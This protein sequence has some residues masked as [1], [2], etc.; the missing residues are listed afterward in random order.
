MISSTGTDRAGSGDA[1][2]AAHEEAIGHVVQAMGRAR[3]LLYITGAGM[4]ADSGLPT[5]RGRDGLYRAQ[6]TTP[7]GLPIER[8]LSGPILRTRPEVTWHYLLELE[9]S[10]RGAMPHRGHEVLAEMQDY[11]DDVCILTQNVDGLHQRAGSRNVIDIHGNLHELACMSCGWRASVPHYAGLDIPP[12]CPD[13][14]G[15]VRP[16]VVLFDED[17][18]TDKLQRL[19][20]ELTTGFD[21][22][23][24]IGTSSLFDY[25][26][27]PVRLG[28][29]MG[30]LT[31][32]I[33]PELTRV[34]GM[35]HLKIPAGAAAVLDA[36]WDRYLAWWPWS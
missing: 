14:Q 18:P 12:R 23:F 8:A 29:R 10:T 15:V 30:V 25:I 31:V 7:H 33:N 21:V 34:S 32:E 20:S 2:L 13:C 11:F 9:R 5:Y 35:V 19:W 28:R 1:S 17:L 36:I 22:I 16:L 26:V 4:S 24:S 27:E 6:E 3:R